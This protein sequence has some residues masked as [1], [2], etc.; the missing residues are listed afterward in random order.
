MAVTKRTRFEVLR[1]D[2][3]RCRYCGTVAAD[4]ELTIDHVLPVSLGGSDGPDNLVAACQGCNAGKASSN[5]DS[6]LVTDVS[7]DA[8]RWAAAVQLATER[9]A[10]KVGERQA[11]IERF[12]AAWDQWEVSRA[13]L[14]DDFRSFIG[15][16]HDAGLPIA[17]LLEC[18]DIAMG[19][20]RIPNYRLFRYLGGI[21]RNR[22]EEVQSAARVIYDEKA[23]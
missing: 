5:P 18:L 10:G 7:D 13:V 12:L 9:L 15:R 6:Q 22:L 16:W 17:A 14:D 11:Y 4:G 21:V 8:L 2:G 19:N 20:R 23:E 1:R 3:Y